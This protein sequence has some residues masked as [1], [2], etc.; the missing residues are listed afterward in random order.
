[1]ACVLYPLAKGMFVK[2]DLLWTSH[3]VLSMLLKYHRYQITEL[4]F[5]PN[6]KQVPVNELF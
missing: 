2:I 5:Y 6:E 1:M 4:I 3:T